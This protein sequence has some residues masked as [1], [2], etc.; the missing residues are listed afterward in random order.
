MRVIFLV[1]LI[2]LISTV[3]AGSVSNYLKV[4]GNDKI[5][6]LKADQGFWD[7]HLGFILGWQTQ[8]SRPGQCYNDNLAFVSSL[9]DTW[10]TFQRAYRPDTWFNF[11]DR[12]RINID[13]LSKGLQSCQM[14]SIL[15]KM[16]RIVTTEGLL[17]VSARLISQIVMLQNNIA[18]FMNYVNAG[19]LRSAGTEMG[20][21]FSAVVGVTVN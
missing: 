15:T 3:S 17:E 6:A 18:N 13:S 7:F 10:V 19:E 14:H 9:S 12:I 1:S 2:L 21:F 20:K 4:N 5:M 8:Q 16:E 11:L